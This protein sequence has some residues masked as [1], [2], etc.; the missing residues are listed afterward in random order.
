MEILFTSLHHIDRTKSIVEEITIS[1]SNDDLITYINA[2]FAE[3]SSNRN[4]RSFSFQSETTEV[5]NSIN[6][7]LSGN[8]EDASLANAN[9]LLRI[10]TQ[11]QEEI[12]HLP[13][14][15]QRGSLFQ[16]VIIDETVTK[17]IITKADHSSILDEVDFKL[18]S[19]LPLNKRIFKAFLYTIDASTREDTV[20]VYDT[21]PVISKY[22]W[23][24]FLELREKYND[25][26][27]TQHALDSIDIRILNPIKERYPAD[28]TILRNSTIR[29]FRSNEEFDL[30]RFIDETFSNYEPVDEGFPRDEIIQKIIALPEKYNFD[31]R[32]RVEKEEIKK[33]QVYKIEI[34]ENVDLVFKDFGSD[35]RGI[36]SPGVEEDGKKFIKIYT[37]IGYNRFK[38]PESN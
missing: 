31:T 16:A 23:S 7:F 10:E 6:N 29:Y 18:H 19:G 8:Y 21:K 11:T 26:Y 22:W 13:Y 2:L 32:F 17:I 38:Q 9:R 37:E 24:G 28:H 30:S 14:E 27:N 15:V 25:S 3:I 20:F 34:L 33:R 12:S 1:E 36:I 4:R 5:K 35:M